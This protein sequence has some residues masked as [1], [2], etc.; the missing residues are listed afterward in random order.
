MYRLFRHGLDGEEGEWTVTTLKRLHAPWAISDDA[1]R[2]VLSCFDLA[3]MRWCAAYAWRVPTDAERDASHT[4]CLAL[5]ERMGIP[6]VP[7]DRREFEAWAEGFE[8]AHFTFTPEAQ[9]LWGATR[10]LLAGR[11]PGALGPLAGSAADSLLD[12]GLRRALGVRR[13]P[14]PVRAVT[15]SA[16]RP[17]A[18]AGRTHRRIR[19]RHRPTGMSMVQ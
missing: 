2:Y 1:Y 4:L 7:P 16:L 10:E 19:G 5:A 18:A 3:P 9:A 17:R 8:R 13:P 12:D 11:V 15:R 14:M 6:D